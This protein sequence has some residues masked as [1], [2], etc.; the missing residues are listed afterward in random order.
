[1]TVLLVISIC[2]LAQE[3]AAQSNKYPKMAPVNEY[4]MERDAEIRL[5]RSA[6]PDSISNDATVV[7]LGRLGYETAVRGKNGFVCL[8]ERGWMAPFDS[9]E[10]WNPKVRGANCLNP[11]AARSIGPII[12]LRTRMVMAGRSTAEILTALKAEFANKRLPDLEDGAFAFMMS[13]SSYLFDA[14]DHNGSHVMVFTAL[15]DGKDWGADA[16][17]S[18]VFAGP[19]WFLSSMVPPE[20]K[21]LPTILVFAVEVPKWSDGTS[22]TMQQE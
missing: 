10:Y 3:A 7:V 12:D 13:K 22:A 17:G 8:V 14:G 21:G 9:P 6:A 2:F 11:Q 1:M 4:L 15:K 5:A 16:S 20:A 18:P 19:Y